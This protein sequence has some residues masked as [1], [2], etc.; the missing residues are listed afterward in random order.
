MNFTLTQQPRNWQMNCLQSW[1]MNDCRG[2]AKVVTGAGKTLVGMMGVEYL[3]RLNLSFKIVVIVPTKVLQLQ[4]QNNFIEKCGVDARIIQLHGGGSN[5]KI[6]TQANIH[7]FIVNTAVKK[8]PEYIPVLRKNH[9]LLLLADECHRY[10]S[11]NNSQIFDYDYDFTL[12]LSATPEREGDF[13]FEEQLIPGLGTIIYNYGYAEALRDGIIPEFK[14]TNISIKLTETEQAEYDAISKLIKNRLNQLKINYSV[15]RHTRK[16]FATLERI[17]SNNIDQGEA[18]D[19]LIEQFR[20]ACMR[21]K[22]MLNRAQE[23]IGCLTYLINTLKNGAKIIIFHELIEELE[24]IASALQ[25]AGIK[26]I[27]YHSAMKESEKNDSLKAFRNR[28]QTVLLACKAL[29]EGLDVPDC[30][31]AIIVASN[32]GIRQRIQRV[33]RILRKTPGKQFAWIISLFVKDSTEETRYNR[34]AEQQLFGNVKIDF[35]DYSYN[36]A[37]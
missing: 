36:F 2:I 9:Q 30:H 12:G 35:L 26:H 6:D 28:P 1:V 22:L 14:L 13:G 33:G 29:D 27:V 21:R 11:A 10:G 4:W 3:L 34:E 18:L 15:L 25:N 24:F 37:I 8:L 31:I 19:P 23:R 32:K 5:K 17:Q 16:L 7:I 20:N